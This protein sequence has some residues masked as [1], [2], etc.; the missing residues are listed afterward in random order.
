MGKELHKHIARIKHRSGRAART[1]AIKRV[2]TWVLPQGHKAMLTDN[3]QGS[4]QQQK[5][6]F[7]ASSASQCRRWFRNGVT[8]L[9]IPWNTGA[10]GLVV[11]V[12]VA[13]QHRE[14]FTFFLS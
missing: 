9:I 6:E 14:R 3:G 7:A 8:L 1:R 10:Y 12:T 13:M 5:G 2:C 11:L 4:L